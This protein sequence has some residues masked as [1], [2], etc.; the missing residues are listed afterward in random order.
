MVKYFQI[1][2]KNKKK[3]LE[4][5]VRNYEAKKAQEKADEEAKAEAEMLER[6]E[7]AKAARAKASVKYKKK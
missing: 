6:L 4:S 7:K 2:L 5:Y 3:K 1:C